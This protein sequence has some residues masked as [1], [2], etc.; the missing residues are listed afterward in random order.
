MALA[1]PSDPLENLKPLVEALVGGVGSGVL[2]ELIHSKQ[3]LLC[4]YA[5]Q[6]QSDWAYGTFYWR[7]RLVERLAARATDATTDEA[8]AMGY[9]RSAILLAA[10]DYHSGPALLVKLFKSDVLLEKTGW[11]FDMLQAAQ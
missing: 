3:P 6:K 1:T 5:H 7:V 9:A 11:P 2:S 10:Q 8:D 4:R